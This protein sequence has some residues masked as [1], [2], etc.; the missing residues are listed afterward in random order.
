MSKSSREILF[1]YLYLFIT[2]IAQLPI[3]ENFSNYEKSEPG[4]AIPFLEAYQYAFQYSKD[5]LISPE[6]FKFVNAIATSHLPLAQP[7][8]YRNES[9]NFHIYPE[10]QVSEEKKIRFF[11]MSYTMTAQGLREFIEY[12]LFT[13]ETEQYHVISFVPNMRSKYSAFLLKYSP[14]NNMLI[15]LELTPQRERISEPFNMETHFPIIQKLITNT[16]YK[17]GIDVMPESSNPALDTKL[18]MERLTDS[19]NHQIQAAKNHPE[20]LKA[21]A[22]YIQRVEQ[23]H[24]FL[25]GNIRT[26]Y[27]ILNKLLR[28]NELPLSVLYNPNLFDCGDHSSVINMI[29]EGQKVYCQLRKN[30]N[31]DHL[32]LDAS[33]TPWIK[34]YQHIYCKASHDINEEELKC[35]AEIVLNI[36]CEPTLNKQQ[37]IVRKLI[38]ELFPLFAINHSGQ[39]LE[40]RKTLEDN[41]LSLALRKSC[42]NGEYQIANKL[43]DYQEQLEINIEECSSNGKNALTWLQSSTNKSESQEA[44]IERLVGLLA[45]RASSAKAKET[46]KTEVTTNL[47]NF[48]QG[49]FASSKKVLNS[50]YIATAAICVIGIALAARL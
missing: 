4:Y 9:G 8:E 46:I 41:Q 43:L 38:I 29:E 45:H 18:Q 37:I 3:K 16:E 40:I 21:I 30:D 5:Q 27:I 35:F 34:E 17:C 44:L 20:K 25:D 48:S 2:D 1:P 11:N 13:K 32:L 14:A 39:C 49:F 6:L 47:H 50:P 12:W 42:A 33:P 7:G 31:P 24:P 10:I 23:L 15:W 26:C 36:P 28:D 22:T 19:Y